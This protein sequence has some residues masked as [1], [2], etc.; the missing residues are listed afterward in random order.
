MKLYKLPCD[1]YVKQTMNLLGY[2]HTIYN[3]L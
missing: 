2:L 3:K 1:K